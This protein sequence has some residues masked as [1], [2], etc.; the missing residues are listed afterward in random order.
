MIGFRVSDVGCVYIRSQCRVTR[1][2]LRDLVVLGGGQLVNTA[3]AAEVVVGEFCHVGDSAS[4]HFVTDQWL[5]DSVQYHVVLPFL[6]YP[7]T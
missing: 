1:E 3:R 5:L 4:P 6:A 2:D 7:L